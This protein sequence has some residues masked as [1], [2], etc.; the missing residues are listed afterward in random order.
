MISALAVNL[1]MAMYSAS[2]A[3]HGSAPRRS[4]NGRSR[5]Y[6]MLDQNYALSM[7][8]FEAEPGNEP[9]AR[10]VGLLSSA[11]SPMIAPIWYVHGLGLGAIIGQAISRRSFALDFA[12]P[13]T[14]LALA[15][16][17]F[18][19][20]RRIWHGGF[21]LA[22]AGAVICLPALSISGLLDRRRRRPSPPGRRSRRRMM[23]GLVQGEL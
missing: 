8:R 11:P 12:V 21:C 23:R 22:G 13:I 1:R 19:H 4:G 14:F 10:P 5:A 6:L 2:L 20:Q 16:A 7:T 15:V 18:A 17:G 3:P 9:A